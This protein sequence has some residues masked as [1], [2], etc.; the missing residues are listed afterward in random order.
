MQFQELKSTPS[1]R[2]ERPVI[3]ESALNRNKG[4]STGQSQSIAQYCLHVEQKERR[5]HAIP[6][7]D[8]ESCVES[9][10]GF[11][12]VRG[13]LMRKAGW[14]GKRSGTPNLLKIS[15]MA[16]IYCTK[17]SERS[18]YSTHESR[19]CYFRFCGATFKL[20]SASAQPQF[21]QKP[22]W[23]IFCVM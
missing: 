21:G 1:A 10:V 13:C 2:C 18:V 16:S 14:S 17:G 22:F 12:S 20:K 15:I 8:A 4:L 9:G 3:F 23:S 5:Y 19:P 7:F 6:L 11:I